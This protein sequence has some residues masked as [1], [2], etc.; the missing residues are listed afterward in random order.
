MRSGRAVRVFRSSMATHNIY[1]P[2]LSRRGSAQ[3]RYDGLY[4]VARITPHVSALNKDIVY[5]FLF[6][7]R[8]TGNRPDFNALS[9]SALIQNCIRQHSIV[10]EAA[11]SL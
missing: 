1:R 6:V 5:T 8:N 7:R 10:Q 4:D 9:V 3:Y 11:L 2:L